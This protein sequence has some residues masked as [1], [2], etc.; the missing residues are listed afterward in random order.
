MSGHS[1]ILLTQHRSHSDFPTDRFHHCNPPSCTTITSNLSRP[2]RSFFSSIRILCLC[3]SHLSR[4]KSQSLLFPVLA[5]TSGSE[6]DKT[7]TDGFLSSR[8]LSVSSLLSILFSFFRL[9]T[10]LLFSSLL[11]SSLLFSSLLFSSLLSS[12]LL[13]SPLLSSFLFS[14]LY[15]RRVLSCVISSSI[16]PPS[17]SPCSP[18]SFSFTLLPT[19]QTWDVAARCVCRARSLDGQPQ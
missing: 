17:S 8:S 13:P 2:F 10:L 14:S 1:I 19:C 4:T 12:P 11:F 9:L 16:S 6:P 5:D 18:A 3:L 7:G 15:S